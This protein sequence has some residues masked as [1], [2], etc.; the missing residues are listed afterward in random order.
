M[1]KINLERINKKH[2]NTDAIIDRVNIF[3][4]GVKY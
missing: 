2:T 3:L 4:K 1:K